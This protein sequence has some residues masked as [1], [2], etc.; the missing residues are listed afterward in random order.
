MVSHGLRTQHSLPACCCPLQSTTVDTLTSQGNRRFQ[1]T[2]RRQYILESKPLPQLPAAQHWSPWPHSQPKN[3]AAPTHLNFLPSSPST[4]PKPTWS[5][6]VFDSGVPTQPAFLAAAN[7]RSKCCACLST[8]NT[9]TWARGGLG[10]VGAQGKARPRCGS[11]ACKMKRRPLGLGQGGF[12]EEGGWELAVAD[13]NSSSESA[14]K[15]STAGGSTR[16]RDG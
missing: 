11:L 3:R 14:T 13:T 6:L 16:W 15:L 4:S 7:T 12:V 9:H 1:C 5:I 10:H 2:D 8:H